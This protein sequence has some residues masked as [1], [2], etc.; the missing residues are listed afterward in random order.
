[1]T[2]ALQSD[3]AGALWLQRPSSRQVLA[4]LEDAGYAARF[5][6]GCV[7]DSLLDPGVNDPDLD[8]TTEALP[9]AVL[10]LA[11]Q[12]G[13]K[14]VPT[15]FAHG[16]VTLVLDRPFEVTTLRRDVATDGRHAKVAFTDS[17]EAD[18]ARRDFT[19]NAM[20][21]DAR[22]QVFDY[23]GGLSDLAEGR[24]EFVGEPNK[25]I[26]EDYLRILRF[27]RFYARF[28]MAAP[29]PATLSALAE[30]RGGLD[31]ISGERLQKE[32]AGLLTAKGA[33]EAWTLMA[34]CG[35]AASL[36]GHAGTWRRLDGLRLS[37]DW[38]LALAATLRG[39]AEPAMIATRLKLARGD[40]E[41]LQDL[42]EQ[43][44]AGRELDAAGLPPYVHRYGR[45]SAI[46]LLQ[47]AAVWPTEVDAALVGIVE[48]LPAPEF[49][50][51]GRDLLTLGIAPGPEVGH[52]LRQ[53]EAV[54]LDSGCQLEREDL[55]GRA[56]MLVN[57]Q[58]SRGA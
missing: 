32:L 1:M 46:G 6:G 12:A 38:L 10:A 16:T 37:G 49:P 28:G 52:I 27:F 29:D 17:F 4:L 50:L 26:T 47:L 24:L 14:A 21:C 20:S 56:G 55:L 11:R 44:L 25:R 53:L 8:V 23:F 31:R 7:R 39:H 18:A 33:Y 9:Q 41:Y 58:L 45:R 5:V 2:A 3:L 19:I 34:S 48:R 57:Q 51:A 35:V 36:F 42:M 43:P 40:G 22:G 30:H 13:I 15:G 54:W